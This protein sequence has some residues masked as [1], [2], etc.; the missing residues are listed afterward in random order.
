ML[1]PEENALLTRVGPGTPMGVLMRRYWMPAMLSHELE[2]DGEPKQIRLLG[3]RFVAFR[4]TAGQVALLDENCPHRG[5]SLA[6]ARNE[7]CG[8]RCIYLRPNPRASRHHR[9]GR[10]SFSALDD[11]NRT[12]ADG[13]H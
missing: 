1:T 3:E 9:F 11:P 4:D 2:A 6:Y 13:G 10:H 12:G 5:A 8:L 7:D